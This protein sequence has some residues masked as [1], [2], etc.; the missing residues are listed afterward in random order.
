MDIRISGD[1]RGVR[2]CEEME[3]RQKEDLVDILDAA[4]NIGRAF[5]REQM[6]D[7]YRIWEI[8]SIAEAQI[9]Q[10]S[11]AEAGLAEL[12][13]SLFAEGRLPLAPDK[14]G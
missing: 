10:D 3:V 4:G 6:G 14:N 12:E 5:L 11:G 13:V 1:A 2:V 8:R 7:E 9:E